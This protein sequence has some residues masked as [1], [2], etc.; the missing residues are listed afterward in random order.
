M[1]SPWVAHYGFHCLTPSSLMNVTVFG[2]S[3]KHSAETVLSKISI[4][5]FLTKFGSPD[6]IPC[7]FPAGNPCFLLCDSSVLLSL[8]HPISSS[9]VST[10]F[11]LFQIW[12]FSTVSTLVQTL[13]MEHQSQRSWLTILAHPEWESPSHYDS[14]ISTD[15]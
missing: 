6:L 10:S 1:A 2:F 11:P 3:H 14:R 15:W 8:L 5:F 13:L 4:N 7:S 9:S 12:P